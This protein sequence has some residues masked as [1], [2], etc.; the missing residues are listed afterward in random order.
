MHFRIESAKRVKR[1]FKPPDTKD[2]VV[3]KMTEAVKRSMQNLRGLSIDASAHTK[4][5]K[6]GT[7]TLRERVNS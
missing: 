7:E 4:L 3:I 1:T 2:A 5:R 6:V